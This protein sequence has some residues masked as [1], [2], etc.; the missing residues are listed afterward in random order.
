M[1]FFAEDLKKTAAQ[2]KAR[3]PRGVIPIAALNKLGCEVCPS[4]KNDKVLNAPKMLPEGLYLGTELYFLAARPTLKEDGRGESFSAGSPREVLRKFSDATFDRS[5]TGYIAQCAS[6]TDERPSEHELECCRGRVVSDIEDCRPK[7]VVG[8]GDDVLH[9]ATGLARN[10]IPFR[11][12]LIAAKFGKHTCWYYP[13]LEPRYMESKRR[14][15][16]EFETVL[17]HDARNLEDMLAS[18]S[19]PTVY[20]APYDKGIEIISGYEEGNMMLL[21][22]ALHDMLKLP[23]LA[24]DIETNMLSPHNADKPLILTAAVGTFDRTV[25]FSIEHPEGW[26]TESR[27]KRVVDAFGEFLFQSGEKVCHNVAFEQEWLSW[28]YG[29]RLLRRTEWGDT[30]AMAHAFDERRGTKSL[31]AQTS[32]VFGF[33]LKAQSPVDPSRANWWLDHSLRAILRYNGMDT[34]WTDK[35]ATIRLEQLAVD[36][37]ANGVYA[38]K[39]ALAPTLVMLTDQ[40]LPIDFDY[41]EVLSAGIEDKV[42]GVNKQLQ[43][44]PST[45][46][47]TKQ[48]GAFEPTNVE[49]V[50]RLMK[51]VLGREEIV[52][53]DRTTGLE[54]YSVDEEHLEAMPAQD[55]PEARL[56]LDIR[57]LDRNQTGY[58]TPLLSGKLTGP[59]GML[60]AEYQSMIT[61]T[62]RLNSPMHNW[63]KHKHKEVRGVVTAQ[64]DDWIVACDYAQIEFRVAGMLSEDEN[65]CK[66][67]WTGYDVHKHWA[68]RMLTLDPSQKDWLIKEFEIKDWDEENIGLK[69]ARQVAKNGWVFPMLF[70]SQS[71]SCAGRCHISESA[72][73]ELAAEFWGEFKQARKWQLK[74][75]ANYRKNL[76]V[77]TMGG[78]RRHG[79]MSVNELINMPIQ[80]TACEIVVEGMNALS[81]RSDAEDNPVIHPAFNGHDDLTFFIPDAVLDDSIKVIAAEMCKP[82]FDYINVPLVVEV[83]VGSRWDKL[84]EV[85]RVSSADVYN[86]RNSFA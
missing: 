7:V 21:E 44:L 78:F 43:A 2:K 68:E 16:S 29:R 73:E 67:V 35:L 85:T 47:Y 76:F 86:Q 77:E 53:K 34:K 30:M 79:A 75:I 42:R 28:K 82:R 52:E 64:N 46:A 70:G 50:L 57:Q 61:V 69:T 31:G 13:V 14:E 83:S 45:R 12:T 65:I 10:A 58:L 38:A 59:D 54:K 37:R 60:H 74:T 20:D 15:K 25:A 39:L 71:T 3:K 41:A 5:R 8:I 18:L 36:A 84:Q 23:R 26:G 49:H 81:E 66:A 4:D 62:G 27:V 17:E 33:D 80:G 63:P 6:L 48:Y 1:S 24:L 19:P 55:V 40:G 22:T 51:D 56:I 9:W 72:A 11:G 32:V